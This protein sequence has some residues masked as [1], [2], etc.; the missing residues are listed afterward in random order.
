[1]RLY[2]PLPMLYAGIGRPT[3]ESGWVWLVPPRR[4]QYEDGERATVG[5]V[6][7]AEVTDGCLRLLDQLEH[8]RPRELLVRVIIGQVTLP[9]HPDE[10]L[11]KILYRL[12]KSRQ[13]LPLGALLLD[14]PMIQCSIRLSP[15]LLGLCRL[16]AADEHVRA[17]AGQSVEQGIVGSTDAPSQFGLPGPSSLSSHPA[18]RKAL[19]D[20]DQVVGV[21]TKLFFKAGHSDFLTNSCMGTPG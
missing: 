16:S 17:V 18:G 9:L 19:G 8:G 21:H 13:Y 15:C 10:L 6:D 4:E 11:R 2:S 3:T 14:M 5:A 12:G 1:M 7:L 20:P